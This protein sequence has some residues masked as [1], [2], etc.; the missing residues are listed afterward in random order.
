MIT[1]ML[2]TSFR[3]LNLAIF[4]DDQVL[5]SFHEEAF[6]SQSERIVAEVDQLF[7]A[8]NLS[9]QSIDA[10]V[11][12]DGPGSYTGL[13]ISMTMAKVLASL[14]PI[15]LF[16]ISSLFAMA[17]KQSEVAVVMDARAQRVYTAVYRNGC[18]IE[19]EGIM[20]LDE[21]KHKFK[22]IHVVGDGHLIGHHQVFYDISAQVLELRDSWK[23]VDN[24]DLLVPRYLKEV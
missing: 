10:I 2:D 9:P 22:D 20:E 4:Q 24:I 1:L 12:T 14:K 8:T 11:L 15:E 13:R 6:K 23:K 5:I 19:E 18:P 3:Y 7:R 16:T 17:G 21:A